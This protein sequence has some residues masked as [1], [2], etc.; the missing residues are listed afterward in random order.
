VRQDLVT[1]V[2][3]SIVLAKVMLLTFLLVQLLDS[4][5]RVRFAVRSL[6]AVA[7]A[8]SLVGI[9]QVTVYYA[10]GVPYTLYVQWSPGEAFKF[11]PLG[12]L[13]RA[14]A[15][16]PNAQM[17]ATI[18]MLALPFLLFR[19]TQP[20]LERG[21]RLLLLAALGVLGLGHLLT[22]NYVAFAGTALVLL[23]FP[24]LRWPHLTIHL[25]LALLL[26]GSL[27]Y[28]AGVV[29]WLYSVSAGDQSI[30]RGLSQRFTLI[31]L[32][33]AKLGRDPW[34]GEGRGFVRYSGNYWHRPVHNAYVQAAA[35][36]GIVGGLIFSAMLAT[37]LAQLAHLARSAA[38]FSREILRPALLAF[39]GLLVNMLGEPMLDAANTWLTLGLVQAM[40]LVAPDVEE[41]GPPGA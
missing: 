12:R 7:V 36:L 5:A 3:S 11:T 28:Y 33:L 17:L 29:D 6:V 39:G 35:E 41:R 27:L 2:I 14:S 24:F 21:Q 26:A 32:G 15:L 40:V 30:A 13:L 34:F 23:G 10:T 8:S 37:L 20:G 22:W 9:V 18:E 25:L 1:Y 31:K 19:V 38:R 4:E 16:N